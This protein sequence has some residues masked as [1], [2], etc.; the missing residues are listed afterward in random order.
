MTSL[1]QKLAKAEMVM[2]QREINPESH[3]RW[4]VRE[5][6]RKKHYESIFPTDNLNEEAKEEF[7]KIMQYLTSNGHA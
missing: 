2:D 4:C 3:V 5:A 6:V 1:D 7:S